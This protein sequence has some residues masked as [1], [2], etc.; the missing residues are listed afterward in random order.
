[1]AILVVPD[2]QDSG[3]E[4]GRRTPVGTVDSIQ[5]LR[6]IAALMVVIYHT[7]PQIQRMGYTLSG[8]IFLSSGVDIFFVISGFVMVH[9]T[10]RHPERSGGAF[11]RDRILRIAP[12]YWTL[13]LFMVALL[14][15][16]PTLAQTSQLDLSHVIASLLFIPWL[17]PVQHTYGPLLVVGW[18][19]N[20]E[21]FFYAIFSI[22]L[23][24][25]KQRRTAVVVFSSA[26]LLVLA[27]VPALFKVSGLATFYTS[28][29]VLEFGFGM[30]LCEVDLRMIPRKSKLWWIVIAIAAI[31]LVSPS[32]RSLAPRGLSLGI[33]ALLIVTGVIYA[34]V[35]LR[36]RFKRLSKGIGDASYS[37]YLSHYLV[38]S[39]LGQL[40][41]KLIP[42]FPGSY[43]VFAIAGTLICSL[44]GILVYMVIEQPLSRMVARRVGLSRGDARRKALHAS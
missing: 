40:W 15:A 7:F 5:Y 31:C 30:L 44:A 25:M 1:M 36:G 22:G 12:L 33:P 41:R 39:A 16:S 28:S 26:I 8:P 24:T 19:L 42:L 20:Y 3:A 13:S 27:T 10:A 23:Y 18:T 43:I 21:M 14:L 35:N 34:P 6:G 37:I 11:L 38:M 32:V 4:I 17:H 2:D 29:M 9:S